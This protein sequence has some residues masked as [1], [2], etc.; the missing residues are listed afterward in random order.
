M[1]AALL[2]AVAIAIIAIG[3]AFT[4]QA[5]DDSSAKQQSAPSVRL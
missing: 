1:K 4:L 3:A 5:L 2:G